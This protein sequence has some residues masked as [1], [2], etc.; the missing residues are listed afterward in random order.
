MLEVYIVVSYQP[1]FNTMDYILFIYI[2]QQRNLRL[3]NTNK[4]VVH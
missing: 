2:S 1:N 4:S 3:R